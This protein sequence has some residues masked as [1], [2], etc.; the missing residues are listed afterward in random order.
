MSLLPSL[1]LWWFHS[2]VCGMSQQTECNLTHTH[3]GGATSSSA[4]CQ[5]PRCPLAHHTPVNLITV[6]HLL[7]L[8]CLDG[9]VLPCALELHQEHLQAVGRSGCRWAVWRASPFAHNTPR[10]HT[11]RP[12]CKHVGR[13]PQH[14]PSQSV[15]GPARPG[16]GSPGVGGPSCKTEAPPSQ[17]QELRVLHVQPCLQLE[18]NTVSSPGNPERANAGPKESARDGGRQTHADART[19]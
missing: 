10:G 7:L 18:P 3:T 19:R 14:S 4:G 12:S 9:V 6:Q 1:L 8:Q 16:S 5:R 11:H 17:G 2:P 15:P 13:P